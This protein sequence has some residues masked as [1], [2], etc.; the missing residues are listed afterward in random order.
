MWVSHQWLQTVCTQLQRDDVW[1]GAEPFTARVTCRILSNL[2]WCGSRSLSSRR[3]TKPAGDEAAFLGGWRPRCSWG[4]K[5][6]G[7]LDWWLWLN[8]RWSCHGNRCWGRWRGRSWHR[9]WL[10]ERLGGNGGLRGAGARAACGGPTG[11]DDGGLGARGGTLTVGWTRRAIAL[12]ARLQVLQETAE[13]TTGLV[14]KLWF[15]W[16]II[17]GLEQWVNAALD[18]VKNEYFNCAYIS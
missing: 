6:F 4:L 18:S 10:W 13:M 17:W 14:N 16:K 9:R 15:T 3:W 12:T 7:W 5:V 2:T 1:T 11:R 8:S